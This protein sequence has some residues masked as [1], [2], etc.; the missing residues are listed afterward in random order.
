[1]SDVTAVF[2]VSFA[3]VHLYVNSKSQSKPFQYSREYDSSQL[4]TRK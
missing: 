4:N 2:V 3:S 1:M